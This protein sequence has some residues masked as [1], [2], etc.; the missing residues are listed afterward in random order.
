MNECHCTCIS[1]VR[2]LDVCLKVSSSADISTYNFFFGL[3]MIFQDL[4]IHCFRLFVYYIMFFQL[5]GL[6]LTGFMFD[7]KLIQ[8]QKKRKKRVTLYGH[9]IMSIDFTLYGS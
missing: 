6:F 9:Y 7:W 5:S 1:P 4:R 8:L 2:K 3:C